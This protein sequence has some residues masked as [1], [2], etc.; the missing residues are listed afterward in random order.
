MT[1][2]SHSLSTL[3]TLTCG[4]QR[5]VLRIAGGVNAQPGEW[6]WQV[7]V[8]YR[9][10]HVC[11]GSLIN[12]QW[13]LTAAHCFYD[14]RLTGRRARGSKRNVSMVIPHENYTSYETGHDIALVHLAKPVRYTRDIAPI[15]LPFADHRFAFG[16]QCWLTGWGDV[17]GDSGGPLVCLE[18][19]RWFQAGIM[20][21]SMSCAQFYGPTLLTDTRAYS[22]WIQSH[23]EGA[24]FANQIE[25][26][27]N[28]T[29][30]YMC[31]GRHLH[32]SLPSL[33][34][35]SSKPPFRILVTFLSFTFLLSDPAFSSA[36]SFV[37]EG[38]V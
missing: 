25:P 33:T 15:C 37:R 35:Y 31:T 34:I 17:A 23:V 7:S 21:S 1:W 18:N 26:I 3:G 5:P 14:V 2:A 9:N 36:S 8:Q 10:Q 4:I 30:S 20:S 27:P 11:G 16:T 29:D 13:V 24:S 22:N 32:L 38:R 12:D 28:T 6:R 19:G